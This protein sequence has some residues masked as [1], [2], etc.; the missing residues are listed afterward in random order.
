MLIGRCSSQLSS[1]RKLETTASDRSVA[2]WR[3]LL[4]LFQFPQP[5]RFVFSETT[6]HL[7]AANFAAASISPY[8]IGLKQPL[9]V[10]SRALVASHLLKNVERVFQVTLCMR[11][12]HT[13]PQ[14]G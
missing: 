14:P 12:G 9:A 2:Q 7:A 6:G 4:F 3:D 1:H 11:G 5:V 10:N 8:L 13:E